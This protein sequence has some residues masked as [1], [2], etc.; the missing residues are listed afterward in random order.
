MAFGAGSRHMESLVRDTSCLIEERSAA[1]NIESI[2]MFD[3]YVDSMKILVPSERW[4]DNNRHSL[5][6][7]YPFQIF[8][9]LRL[10][11]IRGLLYCFDSLIDKVWFKRVNNI[12]R[13]IEVVTTDQ[14]GE[15]LDWN[16][17]L[18]AYL[19]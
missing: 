13:A 1:S 11:I 9:I 10:N 2:C 18:H 12:I 8:F 16:C 3:F 6:L 7:L 4:S 19:L 17:L 5:L 14:A 15:T